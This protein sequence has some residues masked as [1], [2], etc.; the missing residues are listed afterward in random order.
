MEIE[1]V[2]KAMQLHFDAV[3]DGHDGIEWSL[4]LLLASIV[5]RIIF[6]KPQNKAC[7]TIHLQ[8]F[9]FFVD[10]SFLWSCKSW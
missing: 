5:H 1:H 3:L 9:Q 6:S 4:L 2:A 7:Q 8:M 10:H